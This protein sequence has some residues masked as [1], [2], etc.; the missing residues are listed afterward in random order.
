MKEQEIFQALTVGFTEFRQRML[1]KEAVVT[2]KS[3]SKNPK[4]ITNIRLF[5]DST[6]GYSYQGNG[7]YPESFCDIIKIEQTK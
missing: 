1:A 2:F 6:M 4:H 7:E 5:S 3:D